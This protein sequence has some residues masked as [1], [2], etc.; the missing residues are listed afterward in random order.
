VDAATKAVDA[1]AATPADLAK[2]RDTLEA[3]RDAAADAARK[4]GELK[5]RLPMIDG[6]AKQPPADWADE[7]KKVQ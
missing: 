2:A 4:V 5:A 1:A 7:A 3:A 6:Y